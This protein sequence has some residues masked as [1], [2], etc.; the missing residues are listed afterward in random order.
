MGGFSLSFQC[1]LMQHLTACQDEMD[2]S[3]FKALAPGPDVSSTATSTIVRMLDIFSKFQTHLLVNW[4]H[5]LP[6][7]LE[8]HGLATL[9]YETHDPKPELARAWADNML[10]VW[11]GMIPRIPEADTPLPP[12]M[13]LPESFSRQKF[14]SW[15]QEAAEE[16][17]NGVKADMKVIVTVARRSE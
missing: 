15:V 3:T 8:K 13:G 17:K 1:K 10:T 9:A 12:G 5:D 16:A 2:M 14:A 4:L 11:L 6:S 7:T